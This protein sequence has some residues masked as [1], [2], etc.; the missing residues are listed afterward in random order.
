MV[1]ELLSRMNCTFIG[2]NYL[3][4]AYLS[5][6]RPFILVGNMISDFVKGSRKLGY[7]AAIQKGIMLHRAIDHFTDNHPATAKAKEIFRPHYRLYSG[8]IMDIVYDHYLA[9]DATLFSESSLLQFTNSVYRTLEEETV[10]LPPHFLHVLTYMKMENWLYHYRTPEGIQKSLR[11][12]VRRASFIND[13]TTA[14][15][16][17]L[18]HYDELRDCYEMFFP[19]VKQMAK[20]ALDELAEEF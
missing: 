1:A 10:H 2:M 6:N 20:Q 11:G 17:F 12:L 16:L 7:T 4:H 3:A 9:N 19:D 5:Y 18:S 15:E 13:S 14:F 8:P